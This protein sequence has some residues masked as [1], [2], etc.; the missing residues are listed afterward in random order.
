ML[1]VIKET[2]NFSKELENYLTDS[3]TLNFSGPTDYLYIGFRKQFSDIYVELDPATQVSN[4]LEAEYY[5]GSW[6]SLSIHDKTNSFNRSGFIRWDKSRIDDWEKNTVSGKELFWIRL[7]L[8]NPITNL[9]VNGINLVFADDFDLKESYPDIMD[10]LPE[11][12]SSF[13]AYHQEARNHILMYLRNKGKNIKQQN[14]YK[15]LDQFDLHNFDEVRQAAKYL[16][17]ANIFY[18]ESDSVDDKWKQKA[19]GFYKKYSEAI[20]LGFLSIDENDNGKVD[21]NESNAIQFITVH[22]L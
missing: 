6:K 2:V 1:S 3:I 18:N 16:A 15:M 17:L 12:S 8:S 11:N 14:R 7:F 13:I 21:S 22:R 4:T 10:F 19:D 9:E 5:G 20:N